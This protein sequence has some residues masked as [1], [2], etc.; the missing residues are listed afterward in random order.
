MSWRDIMLRVLPPIGSVAPAITRAGAFGAIEG[1]K[2]PSSV[3]HGGVDFNYA[4]GQSGINL[5]HPALRSPVAGIVTNAGQGAVG[6]IAIRD[7]NGLSH[8]LLHTHGRYVSVGDPVAA[9]QLIGTMGNTGTRDQHVHYQLKDPAGNILNPTAFWDQQGPVDANPAPPALLQEYQ[10]YLQRLG[11]DTDDRFG[12]APGVGN[13]PATALAPPHKVGSPDR[14]ESFDDRFGKW[15]SAPARIAPSTAIDR[16][17]SFNNRYGDWGTVP[18]GGFGDAGSAL[19]R[20]LEKYGSSAA[21]GDPVSATTAPT[22]PLAPSSADNSPAYTFDPT[23][24]PPPFSPENYAAAYS[25][26]DKWIASL[27]GVEPQDPTEFAP[28]PIFSPLYRR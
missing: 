5:S 14:S 17:E 7:A 3:P 22:L 10:R 8:E 27:A 25:G 26:I 13:P 1:R 16:S 28:P 20:A 19:L 2:Y 15:A 21:P 24:P 4:V 6:R 12:N 18:A 23:K 9:G 11:V